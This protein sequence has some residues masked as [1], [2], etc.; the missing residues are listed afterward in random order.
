MNALQQSLRKLN[1]N[2]SN[3][4]DKTIKTV[5]TQGLPY[6]KFVMKN[7]FSNYFNTKLSL[8]F[9]KA[10]IFGLISKFSIHT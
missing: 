4:F 8:W 9:I 7:K 5:K 3:D 2:L 1:E 6:I 10:I